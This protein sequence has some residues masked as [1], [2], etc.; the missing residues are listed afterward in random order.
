[1]S[2]RRLRAS[3]V[4]LL[5][6]CWCGCARMINSSSVDRRDHGC[7]LVLTGIE[8]AHPGHAC[9]VAGLKSGGVPSEIEVIDW[10][11]GVP[12]LMLVH[13]RGA[14]RNQQQADRIAEKIVRY[15]DKYPGRPVDI[16]GHSG[17]GG[18]ALLTIESLPDNR[19]VDSIIL[20][21]AAV[22]PDF[23]L[24]P[25]LPKV[26]R[27][28]WNYTSL[29]GDA[30]LLVAGTTA[31]GTIDGCHMPSAGARGFRL[32]VD[33]T[34]S[35]RD[36]YASKL[37]ER[38]YRLQMAFSGNFSDH[39]GG[40]NPLFAKNELALLLSG[41]DEVSEIPL[42]NRLI[43]ARPGHVLPLRDSHLPIFQSLSSD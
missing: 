2:G 29:V 26:K 8:G 38:P 22:S 14:G 7:T 3:A 37:F 28:I 27:G 32:P 25:V 1:M 39:F 23:D 13:L 16:I 30:P 31:F 19:L 36:M 5:V 21:A 6:I 33:A 10:T 15:Q 20:L 9:F 35:E 42:S 43:T 18:I 40:L 4:L 34:H 41:D 24:R 12:A 11:T 17:G